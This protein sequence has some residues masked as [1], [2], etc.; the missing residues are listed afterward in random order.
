MKDQ[1]SKTG[2]FLWATAVGG[3]FFL[4]PLAVVLYL[5]GQVFA[6]V[7]AVAVPLQEHLP[8]KTPVGIGLI[9]VASVA[10]LVAVCFLSGMIATRALGRRFSKTIENQLIMVFPKYAIYKDLL[11]GN[12]NPGTSGPTLS[13]VLVE[14]GETLRLAFESERL[15]NGMVVIFEPGAPDAWIGSVVLV[16]A[17]KVHATNIQFNDAVG[18]FERLGRDSK[19]FFESEKLLQGTAHSSEGQ[20]DGQRDD[21]AAD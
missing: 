2:R 21:K 13:P 3:I 14:H 16:P 9:L 19:G 11:A 12:L 6:I 7:W 5:V 1:L 8:I 4:L 18:I 15:D 10:I 20:T 17:S